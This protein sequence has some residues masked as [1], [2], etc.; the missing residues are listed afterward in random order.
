MLRYTKYRRHNGF[1]GCWQIFAVFYFGGPSFYS[2]FQTNAFCY[3]RNE[4]LSIIVS[5]NQFDTKLKWLF[6]IWKIREEL[7]AFQAFQEAVWGVRRRICSS[8]AFI[9]CF[10]ISHLILWQNTLI[11]VITEHQKWFSVWQTFNCELSKPSPDEQW[12]S[13]P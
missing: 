9:L 3:Q 13:Y 8:S 5:I 4:C 11:S 1:F 10:I 2:I 6:W 12:Q 7:H